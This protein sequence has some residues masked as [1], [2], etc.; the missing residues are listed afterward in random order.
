VLAEADKSEFVGHPGLHSEFQASWA[1]A[2]KSC[3]KK[4]R[5]KETKKETTKKA[6]VLPSSSFRTPSTSQEQDWKHGRLSDYWKQS[7]NS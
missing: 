3:L 2:G 5:N 6:L 4:E 1:T 7:L